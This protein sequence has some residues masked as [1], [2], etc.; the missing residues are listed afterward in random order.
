MRNRVTE[1]EG[2][3]KK[4]LAY[5]HK[6]MLIGCEKEIRSHALG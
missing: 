5:Y 2:K 4:G 1:V 3:K 6:E